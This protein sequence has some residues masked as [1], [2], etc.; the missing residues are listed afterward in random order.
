MLATLSTPDFSHIMEL[1]AVPMGMIFTPSFL[2]YAIS[3][4]VIMKK[5][6]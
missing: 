6:V 2:V 5:M 3:P 1:G 4:P